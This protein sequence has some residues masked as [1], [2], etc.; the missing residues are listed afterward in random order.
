MGSLPKKS[1]LQKSPKKYVVKRDNSGEIIIV[2]KRAQF[3]NLYI[4]I[5]AIINKMKLNA[6]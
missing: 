3:F 2:T 1:T 6:N 4:P 5:P